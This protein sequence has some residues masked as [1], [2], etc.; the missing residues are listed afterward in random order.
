MSASPGELFRLGT[1]EGASGPNFIGRKVYVALESFNLGGSKSFGGEIE[2][3]GENPA[4]FRWDASYSYVHVKDSGLCQSVL[5]FARSTPAH[6]V[7]LSGGYSTGPWE[8]DFNAQYVS[9]RDTMR[10][11]PF[12]LPEPVRTAGYVSIGGRIAND[13]LDRYT[14]AVAATNIDHGVL[15]A[16]AYPAI[17]RQV[18]ATLSAEF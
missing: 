7:R 2:L 6:H 16:S 8:F 13:F 15:R 4:G 11:M 17:E 1:P 18:F 9:A 10:L 12:L 3:K 14:L 5:D